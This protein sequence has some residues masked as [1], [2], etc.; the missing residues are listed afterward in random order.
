MEYS[1]GFWR[2][3]F[4]ILLIATLCGGLLLPTLEGAPARAA[5]KA[6]NALDV[7]INEVAWAGTAASSSAEWIEL[8]NPTASAINLT[9]WKL[10]SITDGSPTIS[11]AGTIAAG[12]YYLLERSSDATISNIAAD[13]TY[14]GGLNNTAETLELRDNT[15]TLID[16]ANQ[17][18]ASWFAGNAT[19][20][21]SM[22]RIN[23]VADG[24]TAWATNNGAV[25]NGLDQNSN[26]INGTPKQPNSATLALTA[27]VTPT[28]TNTPTDTG[29]PT[30]TGTATNTG[31]ST[32]TPTTTGTVTN[33]PT[34]TGFLS[35]IINEVAWAGTGA[36]TDDEWIELYNPGTSSV[37]LTGWILKS[38][39]GTPNIGLTGTIPAGGFFLLERTDDSTVIDAA[40]NQIYSG[41]LAN[42]DEILQLFDVSN[43][44]VDT[45]N[46]NG[47]AWPAGN[48][49]TFNSMERRGV[50]A[51]SDTAW[52][53]NV[54]SSTWTK[55]DARGTTSTNY[56]IHGTP[57]YGNWAVSVTP[58]FSPTPTKTATPRAAPTKTPKPT[59]LPPPPLVA[60]NEFV[61]RP[62]HDWNGDGVINVGDEYIELLNHGVIDVNLSGYSLDDEVNIGSPPYPLPA[63]TLK[64]GE[65]RV[66]YG[67]ETGLLL[68]DGGDGVRLL[69]PNGQL[70]DA[71]NYFVVRFPDQSYCRLPDN[72]GADDW[73][74]NCFP[75]PGLQNSLSGSSVNPPTTGGEENLC[76]IADT[77][78]PDFVLAECLPF[79]N[80]IWNPAYWDKFGWYDERYLPKSPGKWPIFVD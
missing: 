59:P 54:Q 4:F 52:I 36:S 65:R 79:G 37:D 46:S 58:T 42:S 27:T 23:V 19:G 17:G 10:L 15:N 18:G 73:N 63:I 6:A 53:T 66:F 51:D 9:G 69:K 31:T 35:I 68:S 38:A 48:S 62:G 40:A 49:T 67:S 80:N 2:G 43:R 34:P 26:P 32:N 70:M 25:K 28:S 72:G 45:A 21:Y 60:I 1:K 8:Y 75:T 14:T 12:G 50:I 20:S 7:V 33:T 30:N 61:P 16:T 74:Q 47:G 55:H 39:D 29:T 13:L 78:P 3:L 24:P 56:L 71:Y 57:G 76:P 5:P 64:P 44:L 41:A 11:L 22:E 77:L